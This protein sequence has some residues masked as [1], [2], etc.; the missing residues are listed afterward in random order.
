MLL[1]HPVTEAIRFLPVLVGILF[2]GRGGGGWQLVGLAFPIVFGLWRF[3]TTTFRI[4]STHVEL[5]RGLVSQKV[6]TARLDR[7]RSVEL[8]STLMHRLT[9]L[10]KV[11]I[12]TGSASL[13]SSDNAFELDAL[14]VAEAE[15]LRGQ[16]LRISEAAPGG[17]PE[18]DA[19]GRPGPTAAPVEDVLLTLDPR[20][21]RYAPFTSSG[22]VIAAGVAALLGQMLETLAPDLEDLPDGSPT[23]IS[24]LPIVL[25]V[26]VGLVV[27][28][29]VFGVVG[30][31]TANW[32]FTLTRR[33]D[34]TSLR[35]R[36]GLLT[37]TETTL[38]TARVRGLTTVEP[39][40][41]R[42]VGAGRLKALVVGASL[43]QGGTTTVVPNAPRAV[44]RR[45]ADDV[46]GTPEPF[47]A[48]LREH[49]PVARRRRL[50]RALGPVLVVLTAAATLGGFDLVS[51]WWTA[52]AALLLPASLW[53]ARDR[54]RRLGHALTG[55]HLVM[56]SGSLAGRHVALDLDGV[57]GWTV[58][59][60]FFQRRQGV[61]SLVAT[62]A[63][64]SQAYVVLDVPEPVAVAL[65]LRADHDLV[66]QFIEDRAAPPA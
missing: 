59:Q 50:F 24:W 37:T 36:R 28:G 22:L 45:T 3:Y 15:A 66:G 30:Y 34:G 16:L 54:Y 38:E 65:A 29:A 64:G 42:A 20:W 60:S 47:G 25:G 14:Q 6:L 39:L 57:I 43:A 56:R 33:R 23:E 32:G 19:E 41:L 46:L 49:G 35:V 55:Q 11:G 53:V 2:L 27:L 13:T 58:S 1:V 40:G 8:T 17:E 4:T 10:S 5:R 21:A 61:A 62:T 44:L 12:G 18:V 7:V 9:G 26:F 51:W 63:A 48:D 52:A 31:L